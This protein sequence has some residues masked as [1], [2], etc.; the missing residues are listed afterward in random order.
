MK[1]FAKKP[2]SFCGNQ[3]FIGEE[4][5][6]E[7]VLDPNG[8]EKAGVLTIVGSDSGEDLDSEFTATVGQVKFTIPIHAEEGDMLLELT[9]EE[10]VSVTDVLQESAEAAK[11][12]IDTIE[13]EN[14][15]ILLDV[16][17]SRKGVKT[18]V[19]AR[20]NVL[21]PSEEGEAAE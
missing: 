14:A 3:F 5:P 18:L 2:C 8:Q 19:R 12:I 13:S 17:D 21:F 15:L 6:A 1:L 20:A 4:I 9:E 10:L 7:Y 11:A 16:L